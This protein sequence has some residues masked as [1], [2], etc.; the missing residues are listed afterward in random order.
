MRDLQRMCADN[1]ALREES[2]RVEEKADAAK[3]KAMRSI[4]CIRENH[5][6]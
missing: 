1:A 2:R 3:E 5:R 4:E 6:N